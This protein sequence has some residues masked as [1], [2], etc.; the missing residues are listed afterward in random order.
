MKVA[1]SGA[2]RQLGSDL[3]KSF[4]NCVTFNVNRGD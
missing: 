4:I 3:V 2:S 1:V